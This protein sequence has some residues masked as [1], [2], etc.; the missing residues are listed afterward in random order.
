M[1][2]KFEQVDKVGIQNNCW[3]K[4]LSVKTLLLC[5][6]LTADDNKWRLRISYGRPCR[7]SLCIQN[8]LCTPKS[9]I[10]PK[11]NDTTQNQR[12]HP[13][14]NDTTHKSTIPPTNKLC[15]PTINYTTHKK[16]KPGKL[17]I[18][19]ISSSCF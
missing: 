14:I 12:Y 2:T 15:H 18:S 1:L 5:Q 7:P 4:Y 19:I 6:T 8:T 11:I 17:I 9:T 3:R 10:P 16:L 13:Q